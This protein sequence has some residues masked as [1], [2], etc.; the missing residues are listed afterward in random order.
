MGRNHRAPPADAY[1][2][3]PRLLRRR[4]QVP[5]HHARPCRLA[6]DANPGAQIA[7]AKL[8][9]RPGD[10][11]AYSNTGYLLLSVIVERASGEPFPDYMR[12]HVFLPA[13]MRRTRFYSPSELIADRAVPYHVDA[14]GA[15][16]HG[17]FISDQ[18]S[19]WG[20]MGILSTARDMARWS[21]GMDSL[22]LLT[23]ELWRLMWTPVR[24]NQGWTF[25]YGFGLN[26]GDLLGHP[27]VGHA[28]TFRVGY[29]ANFLRLPDRGVSIA[30]LSSYWGPALP[31]RP[32]SDE[33]LAIVDP[34]LAPNTSLEPKPDPQPRITGAILQLLRGADEAHGAIRMTP[35][36]RS[37]ELPELRHLPGVRGLAFLRCTTPAHAPP[38]ALGSPVARECTYRLDADAGPPT[39]TF[40][41]TRSDALAGLGG[42]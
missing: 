15:V 14:A 8:N 9:F 13:G 28:G 7:A 37:L 6:R 1:L 40:L 26:E 35:A 38:G 36:F 11:W 25:P 10:D 3:D 16:T 21:L 18:F 34:A 12:D 39:V 17:P 29:S 30:V 5:E 20:D 19:R 31:T 33:L 42:W 41:L 27:T 4:R 32:L 23:P 22:R 2:R 24:L